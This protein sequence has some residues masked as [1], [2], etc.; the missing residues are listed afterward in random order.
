MTNQPAI[1]LTTAIEDVKG[2]GSRR[3][4]AFRRIGIR[5]VADLIRHVPT[6]YETLLPEQTLAE[7]G[8]SLG[9]FDGEQVN[10]SARGEVATCRMKRGRRT[11]FEATLEDG[12]ATALL[13]WFNAGW[14][15]GRMHPG[16]RIRVTGKAKRYGDYIQFV[17]P[18][19]ETLPPPTPAASEESSASEDEPAENEEIATDSPPEDDDGRITEPRERPVYPATEDLPSRIIERVMAGVLD[20]AVALI[21]D[22]LHAAYRR[23]RALPPLAEAYRMIHRPKD[24]DEA[25]VGRRR[26]A[27]DELLMLQLG[28]MLKRHHRHEML[29]APVLTVND[30]I[31]EHIRS[32]FPFELTAGQEAAI[33]EITGDVAQSKPMNRL[34]QGDVGAGKTVVALYAML[35]AVASKHQAAMMA[36]TEL[37]AEQHFR[38][39]S[40]MLEGSTV[41]IEL[42][43]GSVAARERGGLLEDLASGAIDLIVGTHALL[44]E[45][46]Q[47]SSLGMAVIDE[48]HRFGVHQRAGLRSKA[49]DAESSPHVLV[50]TATPIPRTLSLTIFGDLDNSI[51]HDRPPGRPTIITRAV[52]G[53]ERPT[54]YEYVSER[55]AQGDQAYIVVPAID[56]GEGDLTDLTTH[57]EH[58]RAGPMQGRSIEALHGRMDRLEREAVMARFSD[59]ETQALVAT[60][61]IEVGVDVP[62]ATIMVIEDA[63]RFGLAQLHQL[64]GRVGRGEKQSLCVLIADPRTE[65]G[66]ARVNALVE[67]DDGFVIA[68]R[69][70]EIRG[71][72]ELFG[73]RQ[74]GL[75]PFHVAELPRDMDLLRLARD[76]AAAWLRD[77]PLLAGER[78]ELLKK[79]LLKQYGESLGLVDVA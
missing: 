79:R 50:M 9:P 5:C 1:S 8:E 62:N 40:K 72:G 6:R 59:G 3:G 46:V 28:V 53:A 31:D 49:N 77:F 27:F 47:F 14:M 76:D 18:Q 34:L 23:D 35:L 57:I 41:R 33:T 39:L 11:R 48:Q 71:P 56:A 29:H 58:L 51:I 12:T 43:T 17:N 24:T 61:V 45:H 19:W 38:S 10:V 73:S 55:L 44:T 15:N 70:L 25:A 20:D 37:L 36:P 52:S 13:T 2:V 42:L 16:D 74:S 22:H 32:R 54:V 67:T 65:D 69:D 63:D 26:L 64:R 21:D 75:P 78:D 60:T 7:V 4:A 68:E 66:Q 30:T